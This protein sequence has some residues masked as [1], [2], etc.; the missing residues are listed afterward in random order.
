MEVG[1]PSSVA[2]ALMPYAEDPETPTR[3]VY[4][5]V[6]VHIVDAVI[7]AHGGIKTR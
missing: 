2:D 3:T 1:Y 5:Y 7:A 6:P 4:A